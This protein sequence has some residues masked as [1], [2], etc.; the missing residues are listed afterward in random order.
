M[1]KLPIEEYRKRKEAL[2]AQMGR[3]G[4]DVLLVYGWKRGQIRYFSGYYPNYVANVA[5]VVLPRVGEPAMFIRFPFDLE[6]AQRESWIEHIAASGNVLNLATDAAAWLQREV[7]ASGHIGLVAGDHVMDEMPHSLYVALEKEL[8][9]ARLVRAEHLFREA[10]LIKSP[11][12]FDQLR[13][14]ARVADVGVQ[15]ALEST[16]AGVSE[17]EPV[18]EAEYAMRKLG[19]GERLVVIASKGDR[20]LI[21]PPESKLLED[22]D[23]V[24]F[25]LA[26]EVDG[27]WVQTAQTFYVGRP[28]MDQRA[29]YHATY[30]A[31]QAG[32]AAAQPGNTCSDVALAAKDILEK[33]GYGEHI[34]QDYG[35]GI[36][37]DLP[38]LPRIEL[39]DST[40]LE[41]GMVL[42]IHPAVRVRGVGGTFIGGTVLI[43]AEGPEALH[44]IAASPS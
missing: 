21:G 3:D 12:E 20:E 32:I 7:M 22:G 36:G 14:S 2:Q 31:Y 29:I 38:E 5:L 40:P 25:E 34:E 15:A 43:G 10:R 42:V 18:T 9:Q 26:V 11:K 37:L 35:H 27:Y 30:R 39:E 6:R 24:I 19:A 8:P 16:R 44:N 1:H 33:A 28:T 4:L 17:Y 23:N 41:V 13:A